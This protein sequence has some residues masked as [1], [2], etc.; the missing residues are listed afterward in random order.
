MPEGIPHSHLISDSGGRSCEGICKKNGKKN[1]YTQ[2]MY[3]DSRKCKVA[4]RK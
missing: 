2:G 1:I 4:R 3:N